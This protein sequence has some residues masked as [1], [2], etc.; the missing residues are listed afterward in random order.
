M[1]IWLFSPHDPRLKS[2][3]GEQRTHFLWESLH[4]F[5]RV[6]TIIPVAHSKLEKIDTQYDIYS[7]CI[8]RRYTFAWAV[9]RV[10]RR[11]APF[12][13]WYRARNIKDKRLQNLPRPDVCVARFMNMAAGCAPWKFAPAFVDIDDDPVESFRTVHK[14]RF[15]LGVGWLLE[16][17]IL[18]WRDSTL[19]HFNGAWIANADQTSSFP[20]L[21]VPLMNL[22]NGPSG[23]YAMT[24][25]QRRMI[26]TVGL[27]AHRPNYEGVDWF[28]KNIWSEISKRHKDIVYF[29]IGKNAPTNY[30]NEWGKVPNVNVL[31]YIE[32]LDKVYEE[33]LAV[34]TPIL[35]GAGTCI[36]VPEAGLHGR[37]VLGTP[38]SLRGIEKGICEELGLYEFINAEEF[39]VKLTKIIEMFNN[40]SL[41]MRQKSIA[42]VCY[43]RFSVTAF[44]NQVSLLIG[45]KSGENNAIKKC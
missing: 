4:R 17:F 42:A 41:G 8:D 3:G 44:N 39:D 35:T 14:K 1:I 25:R 21:T 5:G 12:L 24:G 28:I 45:A 30:I 36:K 15:A 2:F 43:E 23:E 27:M 18:N 22:A 9:Q 31:G 16:R 6:I 26:M 37:C 19:K 29:V 32:N 10:M 38:F 7:F 11:I 13:D 33:A 40:E 34:V 20:C